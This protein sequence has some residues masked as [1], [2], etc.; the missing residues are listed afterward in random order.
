M[1]GGRQ[2]L[3]GGR[4]AKSYDALSEIAPVVYLATDSELG[5]VESVRQNAATIASMFGLEDKVD[6]LMAG[7]DARIQTLADFAAGA[8]LTLLRCW[9]EG[10]DA[11]TPEQV[12]AMYQQM[13]LPGVKAA[14][15]DR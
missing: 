5:V 1:L 14:L 3:D 4:L 10:N 2:P 15:D 9:L 8:F 11:Y 7:F 12:D 13:V 6:E